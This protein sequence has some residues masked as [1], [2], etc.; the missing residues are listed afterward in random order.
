MNCPHIPLALPLSYTLIAFPPFL[1]F[2]AVDEEPVG[3]LFRRNYCMYLRDDGLPEE[4][5]YSLFFRSD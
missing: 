4:T 2:A 5:K 1:S 3:R